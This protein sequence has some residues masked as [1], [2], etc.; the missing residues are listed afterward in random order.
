MCLSFLCVFG[1][2]HVTCHIGANNVPSDA[3]EA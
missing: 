2:N 3:G 1:D